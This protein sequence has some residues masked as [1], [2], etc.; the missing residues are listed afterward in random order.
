MI[1]V[2]HESPVSLVTLKKLARDVPA[3]ADLGSLDS[4]L[5]VEAPALRCAGRPGQNRNNNERVAPGRHR[6]IDNRVRNQA[7]RSGLQSLLGA[8]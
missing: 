5:W 3:A 2:E 6:R 4:S 7:E 1:T 8:V